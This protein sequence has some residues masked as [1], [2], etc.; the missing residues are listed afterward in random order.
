MHPGQE[1]HVCLTKEKGAKLLRLLQST[2][3]PPTSPSLKGK[4]ND[5]VS[6]LDF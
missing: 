1:R 3:V 2:S 4:D 5:Y 6:V